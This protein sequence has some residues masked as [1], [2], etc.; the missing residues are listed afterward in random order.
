MH[1]A[2][3]LRPLPGAPQRRTPPGILPPGTVVSAAASRAVASFAASFAAD[4]T[5]ATVPSASR[6]VASTVT[7]VP[8]SLDTGEGS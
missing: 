6:S 3:P 1:L 4:P 5:G 2:T 7:D 8:K